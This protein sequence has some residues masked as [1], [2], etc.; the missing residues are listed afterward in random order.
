[1]DIQVAQCR[2]HDI[3]ADVLVVPAFDPADPRDGSLNSAT[4]G[5]VDEV[6]SSGEFGGSACDLAMLHRPKSLKSRR[7]ALAGGGKSARFSEF[8]MRRLTGAAVR[9]LK[10]KSL[11]K[12]ALWLPDALAKPAFAQ[13]VAE[14]AIL[15]D[16]E[17]D[18][19]KTDPKKLGKH[20]DSLQIC[21][22]SVSP[23][24]QSAVERGRILAEAQNFARELVN[25]PANLLTPQV[26][27]ERARSM[28][29]ASGLQCEVLDEAQMREIGMGS[30]LGVSQ[31]SDHPPAFIV[32]RYTPDQ[33]AGTDHLAF[34]GKAVTFDSG[35][36]S[37]KPADGME[38][39]KYDMG[40]GAAVLGSMRAISQLKPPVRV[41]AF[42]PSV[43]NMVSGR[44][45]RPGDI[46]TTLSGKTVEVLNTDAEGRL[47]LNDA[48]TYA[49][50]QGVTHIVDAATL[51]GS[52]VVALA[53]VYI[54]AFSND[55]SL[56]GRVEAAGREAGDRMW[57]MPL[58]DDYKEYLK[59]AFA[60]VP[61][62][63]GRW[64][65]SITAAKFIEEFVEGK[66]WVHLDIAGTGWLDDGKPWMAK[67]PTGV[68]LRTFAN[69]ALNW[70]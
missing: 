35:G 46:V 11:K 28:A 41:T 12:V 56:Y 30:L 2:F 9:S 32:I 8:E 38:K 70:K 66:P 4:D 37:I 33:A 61:N 42:I 45:Q 64:G 17:P 3:D 22:G 43:E 16:F 36:I 44:A 7:L 34:V 48:I 58:D 39:M 31:G 6:Y 59:S 40:G 5:W 51:T 26:L 69:L 23:E 21:A 20:I 52:I 50:R 19:L 18:K 57:R 68:P 14:A 27:A 25:E 29:A 15:A 49:I 47:I 55:D 54:G 53:H 65:G 1:M 24:L 67:G 13:A 62:I 63:G 60:D 10:A